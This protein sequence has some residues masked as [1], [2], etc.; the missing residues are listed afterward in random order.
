MKAS[1]QNCTVI[2]QVSLHQPGKPTERIK[3]TLDPTDRATAEARFKKLSPIVF[4][5]GT[6]FGDKQQLAKAVVE[7]ISDVLA[8][9]GKKVEAIV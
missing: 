9:H 5:A 8:K 7:N 3:V 6:Q 4:D 2:I 1:K